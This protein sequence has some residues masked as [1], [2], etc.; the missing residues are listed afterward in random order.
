MIR[1]FCLIAAGALTVAGV[2]AIAGGNAYGW[3]LALLFG[4]AYTKGVSI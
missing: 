1:F 3:I 2:Y 4:P